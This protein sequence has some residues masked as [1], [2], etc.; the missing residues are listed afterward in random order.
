[1][2]VVATN[3]SRYMIYYTYIYTYVYTIYIYTIYPHMNVVLT[4]IFSHP[5]YKIY[6][7]VCV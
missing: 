3:R 6:R 5:Y 7:I 4:F 1:M 2:I